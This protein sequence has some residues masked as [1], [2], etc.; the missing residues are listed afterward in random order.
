MAIAPKNSWWYDDRNIVK[1]NYI[2][3]TKIRF[4]SSI[5]HIC[6]LTDV[7]YT[8]ITWT[9]QPYINGLVY[10]DGSPVC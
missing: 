6:D 10:D 3:T 1:K 2:S 4:W 8:G 7:L 9:W 5:V